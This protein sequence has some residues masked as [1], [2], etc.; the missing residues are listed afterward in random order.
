MCNITPYQRHFQLEKGDD[1][2]K[3]G[4]HRRR[5]RRC[6]LIIP[7][8]HFNAPHD[9][10]KFVLQ[11]YSIF[12]DLESWPL[13]LGWLT[14]YLWLELDDWHSVL[15]GSLHFRKNDLSLEIVQLVP[16]CM[17]HHHLHLLVA[18]CYWVSRLLVPIG[19]CTPKN[20][21]FAPL[22]GL[23]SVLPPPLILF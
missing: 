5:L 19:H 8:V 23:F 14:P 17:M 21:L 9:Q 7:T 16:S 11:S 1:V 15:C 12:V 4:L 6:E 10:F 2:D 22:S 18:D 13:A 3:T 20:A